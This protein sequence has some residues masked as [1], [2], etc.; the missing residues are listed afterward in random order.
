MVTGSRV[1]QYTT[2]SEITHLAHAHTHNVLIAALKNGCFSALDLTSHTLTAFHVPIRSTEKRSVSYFAVSRTRPFIF[3]VRDRALSVCGIEMFAD[4]KNRVE[5]SHKKA[6]SCISS[7]PSR[8]LMASA[9]IDGN[10]RIWDTAS[11]ALVAAFDETGEKL[12]KSPVTSL[13]F[14][15]SREKSLSSL[16]SS[17]SNSRHSLSTSSSMNSL[18]SSSR[19]SVANGLPSLSSSTANAAAANGRGGGGGGLE[20]ELLITGTKSGRV[21]VWYITP[22]EQRVLATY[23]VVVV[24]VILTFCLMICLFDHDDDDVNMEV[25]FLFRVSTGDL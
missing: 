19:A 1:A 24:V 11:H 25:I 23:V 4:S 13:C 7:H 8:N 18:S 16:S 10:V 14:Y 20:P 6:I 5:Y 17:L 2:E 15:S 9:S 21:Q 12:W 22:S 3:Y